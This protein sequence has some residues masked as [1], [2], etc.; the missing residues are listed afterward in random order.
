MKKYQKVFA[1][2]LVIILGVFIV[3]YGIFLYKNRNVKDDQTSSTNNE[4]VTATNTSATDIPLSASVTAETENY[5]N[6][7][8][9][10]YVQIPKAWNT[11]DKGNDVLFGITGYPDIFRITAFTKTAWSD[12]R[13]NSGQTGV[14]LGENSNYVFSSSQGKDYQAGGVGKEKEIISIISTF[15][16]VK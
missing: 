4:L 1:L 9:G 6:I 7:Q 15:K 2:T 10:F 3:V 14:Y 11:E 8:F 16:V 12:L 5:M 13:K